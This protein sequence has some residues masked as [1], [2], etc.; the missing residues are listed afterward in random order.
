M[1]DGFINLLKPPGMSSHDAINAVRKIFGV[2]RVGQTLR[3]RECCPLPWGERRSFWS[4][5]P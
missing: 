2:K 3:R 5:L 1:K 4:I